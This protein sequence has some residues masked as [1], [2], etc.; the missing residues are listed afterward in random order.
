M[1]A[2][3]DSAFRYTSQVSQWTRSIALRNDLEIFW[4]SS[5]HLPQAAWRQLTGA[6]MLPRTYK[7]HNCWIELGL[8]TISSRGPG[9]RHY[10]D[11]QFSSAM[12]ILLSPRALSTALPKRI[13]AP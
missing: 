9:F 5:R 6:K 12:L 13:P 7:S 2:Y 3:Y 10:R 8:Q 1:A 4:V 11:K